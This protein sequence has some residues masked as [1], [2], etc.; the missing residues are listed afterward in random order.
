MYV[1]VLTCNTKE[2]INPVPRPACHLF[3]W[4]ASWA[5]A[6][7]PE[8]EFMHVTVLTTS[9]TAFTNCSWFRL[10]KSRAGR[11][12]SATEHV[13]TYSCSSDSP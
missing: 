1:T 2:M 5:I 13:L 11:D 8:G 6:S 4:A 9:S 10:R 3:G 7:S 12:C